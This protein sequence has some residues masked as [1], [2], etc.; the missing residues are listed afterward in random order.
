M[1]LMLLLTQAFLSALSEEPPPP[2]Q[3][4]HVKKWLLTWTPPTAETD[5]TYTVQSSFHGGKW[6][7]VPI[8]VHMASTSCDV[9]LTAAENEHGCVMLRV[10][11]ERRGLKS[12]PVQACSSQSD[13]CT[14]E[15]SLSARP[16]FLTIHL[17]RNHSLAQ[18][19]AAHTVYRVH[20]S[21][22]GDTTQLSEDSSSSLTLP[23]LEPGQRYC[24]QVEYIL[25]R[26]SVGPPSCSLCELVPHSGTEVNPGVIVGVCIV[27]FLLMSG[28]AYVFIFQQRRIKQWLRPPYAIP[29]DF[30]C[31]RHFPIST[32]SLTEEHL[33]V[34]TVVIPVERRE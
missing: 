26:W 7:D 1:I 24:A 22:E 9:A 23:Q 12:T 11:A 25:H 14:P 20:Y 13:S 17:S 32:Y 33:D 29:E 2:P 27:L 34:I 21:R 15:V 3:H 30:Y 10:Q 18:N 19:H 5:L 6:T 4:V 16:G 8:C 31:Q 28:T